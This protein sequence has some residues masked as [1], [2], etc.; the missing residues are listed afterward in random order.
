MEYVAQNYQ[1][2][3]EDMGALSYVT[4]D[5]YPDFILPAAELV[6][7]SSP[8]ERVGAIILGGSGQGEAIAANR[9][10]G[11]RAIVCYSAQ[12][13]IITLGREHNDAN[14]LSLGA[15]FLTEQQAYEMMDLFVMT[16]FP[17]EPRHL[18]RIDKIDRV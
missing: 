11:V 14:V 5:D 10:T 7:S 2:V 17:E 15:R 16:V 6:G 3:P 1:I 18:R 13:E 9:V 4:T 12:A 8:D